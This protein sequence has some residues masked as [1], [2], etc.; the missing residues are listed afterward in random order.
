MDIEVT[1]AK[2]AGP[3]LEAKVTVAEKQ[4]Q[5]VGK[6]HANFIAGGTAGQTGHPKDAE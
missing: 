2:E 5:D 3:G 1:R 4:F 6:K